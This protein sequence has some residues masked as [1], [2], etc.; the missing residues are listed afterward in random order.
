VK[1]RTIGRIWC[2]RRRTE[3]EN[4][5]WDISNWEKEILDSGR[6]IGE[7]HQYILSTEGGKVARVRRYLYKCPL[8]YAK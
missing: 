8:D 2:N 6:K 3:Y 7:L 1:V 4:R 5:H